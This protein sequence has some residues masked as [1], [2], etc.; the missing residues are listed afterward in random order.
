MVRI[1]Y[2]GLM[3]VALC[4][5]RTIPGADS[6]ASLRVPFKDGQPDPTG[7]PR[8][9][10]NPSQV[11]S[12][13]RDYCRNMSDQLRRQS[14]E[15]TG[16][17]FTLAAGGVASGVAAATVPILAQDTKTLANGSSE[18]LMSPIAIAVSLG[19]AAATGA[20]A[21]GAS[22]S[23]SRS[24]DAAQASAAAAE[25]V[26]MADEADVK[27]H[28]LCLA[29]ANT[30]ILSREEANNKLFQELRA[31]NAE[32]A[33]KKKQLEPQKPPPAPIVVPPPPP[34]P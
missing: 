8:Y 15:L 19:L 31:A 5:C 6:Y 29:A 33:E 17:G 27:A 26:T 21:A 11:G 34:D 2:I 30:Y 32:L 24:A 28:A 13:G 25:S 9:A 12:Q 1:W 22:Y 7:T 23:F 10:P 3:A 20:L 14:T 16:L 18:S 4:G